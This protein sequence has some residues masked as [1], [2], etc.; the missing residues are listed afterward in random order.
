MELLQVAL[1][2]DDLDG[3]AAF[4]TQLL[5]SDPAGRFDPPGLLFFRVGRARL[6]LER[7]APPGLVYLEVPDLEAALARVPESAERLGP[8]Q[9]IFTHS[10]DALGPAGMEEWHAGIRDPDGNLVVLVALTAPG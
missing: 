2:A 1:H 8:P 6:L 3:A 10:D 4:Y 9:R 7:G 5:G